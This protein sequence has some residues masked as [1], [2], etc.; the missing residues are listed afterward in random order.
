M[1]VLKKAG[2]NTDFL[3]DCVLNALNL[4]L[5]INCLMPYIHSMHIKL[6]NMKARTIYLV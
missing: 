6:V 5:C 4:C 2:T 3:I 1:C